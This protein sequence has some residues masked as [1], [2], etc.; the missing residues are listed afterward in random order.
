MTERTFG[1]VIVKASPIDGVG[2]FAAR[3]FEAGQLIFEMR[4]TRLVTEDDPLLDG[5]QERHCDWVADG[6]QVLLPEPGRYINHS[7][8]PN[9]WK[10][11]RNVIRR[12]EIARRHIRA[13]EEITH[14]YCIDGFGDVVWE[15]NCG[16]AR[17]RKIIHSDFF[18]L[19]LQQ[20]IEY[21]PYL[22]DLYKRVFREKLGRLGQEMAVTRL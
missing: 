11:Y 14:D 6:R 12:C 19:P 9:A 7:C 13:G 8:D 5:E 4:E 3:D 22:S 21:L 20:K 10:Q 16:S 1:D 15:C 18:E 17:C 2:V